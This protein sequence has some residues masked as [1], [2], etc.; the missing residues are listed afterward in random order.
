ME[1]E[2]SDIL[3][4]IGL[5]NA[6]KNIYFLCLQH[7]FL[8]ITTIARLLHIPRTSINDHVERLVNEGILIQQKA[9]KWHRFSAAKANDLINKLYIINQKNTEII[10]QIE[11]HKEV[12]EKI[13]P[14]NNL[15]PKVKF[16]EWGEVFKV[17]HAKIKRSW[18][19]YFI[20][21]IDAIIN[22][23]KRPMT[24]LVN[25]FFLWKKSTVKEIIFDTPLGRKYAKLMS[26]KG[27]F[28]KL[29]PIKDQQNY[30]SDV[31]LVDWFYYHTTFW[32]IISAVE[33]ENIIY[34]E[35]NLLLFNT[36][37]ERL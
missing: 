15:L 18:K 5:S 34:Y 19:W 16:Y 4:E 24:K 30:A 21:N 32:Q 9:S 33:I 20:S 31:A 3:S 36:I 35:T 28:I 1:K 11:E 25:E 6:D 37:R 22:Y 14:Y 12:R 10:K 17:I 13:W 27:H 23:T 8:G 26:K 7:G 2:I 29:L